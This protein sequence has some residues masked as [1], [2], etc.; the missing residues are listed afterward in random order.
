[1]QMGI[2][3]VLTSD[4]GTEFHNQINEELMTWLKVDHRLSTAY[5]PHVHK[6]GGICIELCYLGIKRLFILFIPMVGMSG[7][8]KP[9]S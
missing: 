1:M 7:S 5:H 8:I 3:R 6:Y 2:P 4:Q 9:F